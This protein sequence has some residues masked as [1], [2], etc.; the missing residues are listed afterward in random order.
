[1]PY[2]NVEDS[3]A[4]VLRGIPGFSASNVTQGQFTVLAQGLGSALILAYDAFSRD[5]LSMGGEARIDWRIVVNLY[6]RYHD[7]AQVHRD[8]ATIRQAVIDKIN[9]KPKL[10]G[11]ANVLNAVAYDGRAS[12]ETI[13]IGQARYYHEA[14]SVLAQ[15]VLDYIPSE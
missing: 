12:R 9:T 14:I 13:T 11:T 5:E 8:A 7:D 2:R 15:E 3:L 4:N 1:M 6:V 10:G